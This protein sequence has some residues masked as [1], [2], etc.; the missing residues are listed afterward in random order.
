MKY[1]R[2]LIVM[3]MLLIWG[4]TAGSSL[5]QEDNPIAFIHANLVPMTSEIVLPDYTVVVYGGQ[6][7][8]V[9]PSAQTEVPQNAKMIDCRNTFLMPGLADMHMHIFEDWFSDSWPVSPMHL[10]IANGVTTIRSF[11][12]SGKSGRYILKWRDQID[13]G[14][15]VGPKILACGPVLYGYLKNPENAVIKQKYQ[16][17]DFIKPYS[18]LTREEY[19]TILTSAK[20]LH[21]Y[22]AGHIPFQVGLEGVL[23]EGMDEIAHVEELVWEFV[24]L[25]RDR[26]F[27]TKGAWMAYVI[28]T[29]FSSFGPYLDL[30]PQDRDQRIDEMIPPI[31][32]KLK[33][34]DVPLCTTLVIDDVIVQ[35]LFKPHLFLKKPE[36]RYMPQGYRERFQA[37]KEKHQRQFK[38]GEAFAPFK[39]ALDKKLLISLK[40]AGIQLLLSTDAGTGGMGIVPGFSLHDELELL[41]DNGFTPYEA[42]AAGTVVASDIVERMIGKNAFGSVVPGKRADLVLL[43]QNPLEDIANT[44]KISGVMAAGRWYDQKDLAAFLEISS[45][46]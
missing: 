3:T 10:Y 36:I 31:V 16:R 11:G 24:D 4:L 1:C 44:R 29:A 37:G 9:G 30:D 46:Q 23:D 21:L 39:Y 40:K 20:E 43:Q 18:Y 38:G 32:S 27:P 35:K 15:L 14:L 34:R 13:K 45:K 2:T 8:T 7:I 33:G 41:V 17:F 25:D 28:R 22:V 5:A 6:I 12:P 42:I 19:H 26:Y